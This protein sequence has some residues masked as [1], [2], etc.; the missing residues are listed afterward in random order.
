MALAG[1]GDVDTRLTAVP[2]VTAVLGDE[3]LETA[4]HV[5]LTGVTPREIRDPPRDEG[6]ERGPNAV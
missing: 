6:E 4:S 2:I 5:A 3:I 1:T